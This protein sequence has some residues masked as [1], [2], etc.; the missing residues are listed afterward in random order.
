MAEAIR[1]IRV[2]V[3]GLEDLQVLVSEPRRAAR[4]LE[5]AAG[6]ARDAARESRHGQKRGAK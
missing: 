3:E 6:T 2:Q 4:S 5:E 1:T